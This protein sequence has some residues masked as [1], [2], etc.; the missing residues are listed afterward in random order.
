M[1]NMMVIEKS[2]VENLQGG[3]PG[4]IYLFIYLSFI[5]NFHCGSDENI[6]KIFFAISM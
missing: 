6:K 2:H 1:K 4:I 5:D 3:V